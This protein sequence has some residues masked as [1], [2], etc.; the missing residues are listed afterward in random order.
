M[1]GFLVGGPSFKPSFDLEF[2][3]NKDKK[4]ALVEAIVLVSTR[5]SD[6]ESDEMLTMSLCNLCVPSPYVAMVHSAGNK[7]EECHENVSHP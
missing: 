3:L 1:R 2:L 4:F 7:K 5:A 6:S